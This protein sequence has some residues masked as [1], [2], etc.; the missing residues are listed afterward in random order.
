[1]S[2]KHFFK[3]LF[4]GISAKIQDGPLKGKKWILTSGS[5]FIKGTFENYKAQAFLQHFKQDYVFFDIGAHFGYFSLMANSRSKNI[6]SFEPRPA[7]RRFFERHMALNK[8]EGV[9]LF[10]YA[11]GDKSGTVRFNTQTG[12]AT[13]HVSS[14]GNLEVEMISIDE[15]VKLN[16]LPKPDFIKI[17][18]EGGELEVIKGCT[19]TIMGYKPKLLI[20]THGEDL[21]QSVLNFLV[22]SEYQYEVLEP[23]SERGDTEIMA[24]PKR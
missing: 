4:S 20:A 8:A 2:I 17:D 10:P 12:S 6:F 21:H 19:D 1:M 11:I 23:E 15:W 14:D 18:V 5:K 9:Q 13:G 16:K 7:N 22:K 24:I 3:Q